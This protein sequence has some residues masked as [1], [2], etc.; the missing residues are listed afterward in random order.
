[1]LD[2]PLLKNAAGYIDGK[3]AHADSGKTQTVINPATDEMVAVV[4]VMGRDETIRAIEAAERTLATPTTIEQ[5]RTWLD[6]I[7]DLIIKNREELGRIVT[8]EHGK[9]WKEAMGEADYAA[10]FFRFYASCIDHLKPRE[11]PDRPRGHRWM[12]H[13]RP[14][15]VAALVTPWNFPLAML[16]KKF[17]A[18][19]AADCGC[20]VK[21]S[22]KTPLS[23]IALFS[24]MESLDLPAG[25]ANLVLGPAGPISDALCEHPAVRIISFTGSTPVGK[26]LM[27]AT[28][29]HLKRLALELGGNAPFIV[30]ADADI[31]KAIEHLMANK[32]RG[33][34]QTCVCANR[35]YVQREIADSFAEKLAARAAALKVGDGMVEGTDMGPLIDKNAVAKV[36]RH[37]DDALAKGAILIAGE[38]STMVNHGTGNFFPP[39]V[40]RGVTSAMECVQDET[41]GPLAPIIE[42]ADEEEVITAA[43][44]TEYGLA[45]YVFTSDD[46]CAQRVIARLS[47]GHVGCNTGS[48]PTAEAPFGGMK[49][50]GF[51]REGGVEGLHDFIEA[52]AV[53]SPS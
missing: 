6:Q 33:A 39:T 46:G 34:G 38:R 11:L 29:P 43:N 12:V 10:S 1:M 26:K 52:Q 37:V 15:G 18:A 51:G 23:M 42:F 24:L 25:K 49:Q 14:A 19:L 3:W 50:S 28:A 7:A 32:F 4:P 48:G 17:S 45:A 21:P 20:V 41:F 16:A 31:D 8:H 44:S 2:S 35:V 36:Q 53:P 13:Y 22:S 9:P 5:R 47:F 27:A 30:F 40:L